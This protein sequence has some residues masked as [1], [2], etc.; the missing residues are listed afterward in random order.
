[1]EAR[2]N[3]WAAFD[4]VNAICSTAQALQDPVARSQAV[5][6]FM[7]E[8]DTNPA[9]SVVNEQLIE[10]G[11]RYAAT[12]WAIESRLLL[13]LDKSCVDA[14]IFATV[15]QVDNDAGVKRALAD[16]ELY[17]STYRETKHTSECAVRVHELCH[18]TRD[19]WMAILS[20]ANARE[21]I[22]ASMARMEFSFYALLQEY[23]TELQRL[24]S[25]HPTTESYT[26]DQFVAWY[27]RGWCEPHEDNQAV[28][29][30]AK[31]NKFA[32]DAAR[33][34]KPTMRIDTV[35]RVAYINGYPIILKK[36]SSNE[37]LIKVIE[38][39]SGITME[40]AHTILTSDRRMDL[41]PGQIK[42]VRD[43]CR[44][45]SQHIMEVTGIKHPLI[46]MIVDEE[47]NVV[48][49]NPVLQ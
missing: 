21:G 6:M 9:L 12:L 7:K 25:I 10:Q 40:A 41:E 20:A 46:E 3:V 11:K 24:R 31:L 15:K 4:T 49:I 26:W 23:D 48:R 35:K 37:L 36:R 34:L 1:M 33:L 47:T 18:F 17:M 29:G 30:M 38:S 28:V 44:Y 13:A 45:I 19:F 42:K 2:D 22:Q 5:Q 39:I 32:Q 16:L 43:A 27:R 14:H 8:F